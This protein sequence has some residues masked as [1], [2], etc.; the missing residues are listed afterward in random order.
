M[1]AGSVTAPHPQPP[2]AVNGLLG[3]LDIRVCYRVA[4][5][6]FL[7]VCQHW[8][9][10][11]LEKA[12]GRYIVVRNNQVVKIPISLVAKGKTH[13]LVEVTL[14]ARKVKDKVLPYSG[15]LCS[16]LYT[17]VCNVG[18]LFPKALFRPLG[19]LYC[20]DKRYRDSGL[21]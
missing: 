16:C 14:Y 21:G 12:Q 20:K 6:G 11:L 5:P 9:S 1:S 2:V 18:Q 17:Y 15:L 8:R 7:R 10:R 3:R 4:H 13:I 19:G